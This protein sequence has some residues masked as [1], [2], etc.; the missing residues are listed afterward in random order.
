MLT[1]VNHQSPMPP[2]DS[3]QPVVGRRKQPVAIMPKAA[4]C[5]IKSPEMTFDQQEKTVL[6]RYI[7]QRIHAANYKKRNLI[8]VQNLE[9]RASEL[10]AENQRLFESIETIKEQ[11]L[12]HSDFPEEMPEL[13]AIPYEIYLEA[14]LIDGNTFL[15]APS[16]LGGADDALSDRQKLTRIVECL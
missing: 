6:D 14:I 9:Q 10:A 8:K 15:G 12:R 13:Q 5:T 3:S 11:Y 1:Q 2:M 4:D 7:R 16:P